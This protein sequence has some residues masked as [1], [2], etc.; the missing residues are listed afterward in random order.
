MLVGK[1][2][3]GGRGLLIQC[4]GANGR[5]V[6]IVRFGWCWKLGGGGGAGRFGSWGEEDVGWCGGDYFL[7]GKRKFWVRDG[8]ILLNVDLGFS[9][10][11]K[12][13]CCPH[14]GI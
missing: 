12:A 10:K 11:L 4:L 13:N 14:I 5:G 2:G 1:G 6:G 9:K 8:L 7:R 3:G